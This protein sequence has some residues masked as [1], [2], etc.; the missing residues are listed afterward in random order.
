MANK[1]EMLQMLE[2]EKEIREN[3]IIAEKEGAVYVT[4]HDASVLNSA[5]AY[6]G[7]GTG[8]Q[9]R[10]KDG[11][12]ASTGKRVHAINPDFYFLNRYKVKGSPTNRQLYV[13]SGHTPEGFRL[14]TEQS[15]GRCFM[16]TIPVAVI[17]RDSETKELTFEKM[18]TISES[19]FISDY[20][21]SLDNKSMAEI[22][23]LIVDKGIEVTADTM[24]I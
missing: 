2:E 3:R 22:L 23:P 18:D 14:I 15:S 5:N 21:K 6:E 17:K 1:Q 8:M 7:K 10:N 16:K 20:T 4:F 9:Q 12:I 13:V 11:S 19:E 24:P